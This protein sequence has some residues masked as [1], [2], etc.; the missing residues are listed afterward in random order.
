L[1]STP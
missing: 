1:R